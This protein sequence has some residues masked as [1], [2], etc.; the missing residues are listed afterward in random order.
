[1]PVLELFPLKIKFLFTLFA[2]TDSYFFFFHTIEN[3]I[4]KTRATILI[5]MNSTFVQHTQTHVL[6]I[7]KRQ[8][9]N[10]TFIL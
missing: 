7:N 4:N 9:P 2:I 1:M 8:L 5:Q 10:S 6:V 3:V